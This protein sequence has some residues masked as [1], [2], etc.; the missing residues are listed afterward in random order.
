MTSHFL[1]RI[2]VTT[3]FLLLPLIPSILV[4]KIFPTDKISTSGKLLGFTINA[5]GGFAGYL[6]CCLFLFQFMLKDFN[7]QIKEESAYRNDHPSLLSQ[8][9]LSYNTWE[10]QYTPKQGPYFTWRSN[11]NFKKD[12]LGN[13]FLYGVTSRK[14]NKDKEIQIMEWK[15]EP[16]R[17]AD[18][19]EDFEIDGSMKWL[20]G[21]LQ[22][23]SGMYWEI[24]KIRKGKIKFKSDYFLRGEF[25]SEDDPQNIWGIWL[26]RH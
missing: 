3:L 13:I 25:I 12:S 21:Q 16:F 17:I 18:L 24:D 23:D 22:F 26:S 9:V 1:D 14:N 20:P 8:H 2:I 11:M 15:S 10:A 6:I 19:T 4:Y 7:A 5:G